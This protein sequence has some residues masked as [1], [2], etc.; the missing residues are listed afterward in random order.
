MGNPVPGYKVTTAFG[1]PGNWAAGK[2]TGED[3]ACP[4]GTPL[5]A[6]SPGTVVKAGWQGD[7]GNRV[8]IRCDADGC[9]HSYSH[10]SDIQVSVN[11]KVKAGAIIGLSG[12]TGNSTGPHCHYEERYSPYGYHNYRKPVHS[13]GQDP[14]PQPP[15]TEWLIEGVIPMSAKTI[16]FFQ[17]NGTVYEANLLAGTYR[18]IANQADLKD[19]KHILTKS[20]I[21]WF[22]WSPGNDVENIEAFGNRV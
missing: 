6:S 5:V 17:K 12:S 15:A 7:Y 14:V 2:H 21:P 4:T 8:D 9:E 20:G 3:Y 22:D 1:V 10:L 19:R 13:T 18:G 11:Q 16:T